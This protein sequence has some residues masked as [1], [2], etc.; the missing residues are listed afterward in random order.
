MDQSFGTMIRQLR[1]ARRWTQMDLA[2]RTGLDQSTVSTI[3]LGKGKRTVGTVSALAG[4][5]G[6]D[7]HD[8]IERAGLVGPR[9]KLP[10]ASNRK[11]DP[12]CDSE[13]I[14]KYIEAWPNFEFQQRLTQQKSIHTPETYA[15]ICMSLFEA[16][17]GCNDLVMDALEISAS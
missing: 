8:W 3:E 6:A 12:T 4:A 16:W 2:E 10:T 13:T 14:I 1:Q 15:R 11:S 7:A 5:F 17:S 9:H